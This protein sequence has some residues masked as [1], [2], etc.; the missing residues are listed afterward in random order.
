MQDQHGITYLVLHV[1]KIQTA[2]RTASECRLPFKISLILLFG[3]F[4]VPETIEE[5]NNKANDQPDHESHPDFMRI[6]SHEV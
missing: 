6:L 3:Q 2:S 5:I 1:A 4:T